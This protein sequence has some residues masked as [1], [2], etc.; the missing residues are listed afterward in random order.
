MAT[1][2]ALLLTG[3]ENPILAAV[4]RRNLDRHATPHQRMRHTVEVVQSDRSGHHHQSNFVGQ[5][6]VSLV[7]P[8]HIADR[9]EPG[10]KG[11]DTFS[12]RL[13]QGRP[14]ETQCCATAA[15][16]HGIISWRP[17]DS[18]GG[19]PSPARYRK[20]T[21]MGQKMCNHWVDVGGMHVVPATAI[22]LNLCVVIAQRCSNQ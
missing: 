9:S 1:A 21:M 3:H 8:S 10:E 22:S 17:G 11:K 20:S 12:S 5:L 13:P 4:L 18:I 2:K 19:M 7:R 6:A 16:T 14:K 15:Q